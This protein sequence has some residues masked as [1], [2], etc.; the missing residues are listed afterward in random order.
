MVCVAHF[1]ASRIP[2]H[3]TLAPWNMGCPHQHRGIVLGVQVISLWDVG[4]GANTERFRP[5][6]PLLP[7]LCLLSAL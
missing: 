3:V 2:R 4:L 1:I 5:L 6:V 7:H